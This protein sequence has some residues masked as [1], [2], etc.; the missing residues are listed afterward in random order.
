MNVLGISL[1]RP[2]FGETT[3]TSIM[4]I[5]L[6]LAGVGAMVQSGQAFGRQ[7]MAA[8]LVMVW[9]GCM[10]VRLGI[11]LR[12]GWRHLLASGLGALVLLGVNGAVWT[13]LS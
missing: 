11:D 12:A 1:R 3:A 4:A 10:T 2:S 6:W 8:L 9:W 5:G 7:D 13:A